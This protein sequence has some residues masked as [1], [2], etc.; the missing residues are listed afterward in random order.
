V[1]L[2]EVTISQGPEDVDVE[3]FRI[4]L[5]VILKNIARN[6][7]LAV[8]R[9]AAPRRIRLGVELDLMPTGEETVRL[10]VEDTSS[11]PLTTEAIYDRRADRGLGLVTAALTRYEGSIEAGSGSDGYEKRVTVRLFRAMGP[12]GPSSEPV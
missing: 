9:G 1:S 5:T 2:D 7:I 3:V 6:A 12:L 4:D 8:G 10:F 11:E